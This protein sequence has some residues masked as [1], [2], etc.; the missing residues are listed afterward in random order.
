MKFREFLRELHRRNVWKVA[1]AYVATAAV[2]LEVLTHLFHNFE[3]P[4]WVLKV[5]TTL[6]ITGLPLACLAAW[7]FE[8]KEGGVHSV[9][10]APKGTTPALPAPDTAAPPSI[11]VLPFAD[12]SAERDQQF[13]GDGIAEELLNALASIEG[14]NVAARTSSFSFAGK[15]A[16]IAEIGS[17]LHVRHVLEGS[18]RMS[19]QKLRVT[20]QL[21]TGFHCYSQ[22]YDR[23][24]QDIFE[25]QN[26][27]ARQIV[28]ALLPKLGVHKDAAL[29]TH[30]TSN[31]EAY[32]VRLRAR[33]WITQPSPATYREVIDQLRRATLLDP[34][35]AGAWSDLA[36]I[37]GFTSFWMA[38]PLPNLLEA[39]HA[40]ETALRITP[41]DML[42]LLVRAVLRT[43][44][45][46][47][48]RAADHCYEL[49]R[50]AGGDLSVWAFNRAVLYDHALGHWDQARPALEEA[51]RRDPLAHNVK[52]PLAFN[53]ERSGRHADAVRLAEEL[54][55]LD[56]ASPD[57]IASVAMILKDPIVTARARDSL[58]A[59]VAAA[60]DELAN[61]GH[62]YQFSI[63]EAIG[64][65]TH[66][67]QLLEKLLAEDSAERPVSPVVIAEG[68]KALGEYERA[69]DWW[70]R[71]VD[72]HVP[73]TLGWMAPMSRMHPVIGKNPRFL[74]LLRRMGLG[75]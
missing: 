47:D 33:Q 41:D 70:S 8:F 73:Y 21:V 13:L 53:Y 30:G 31:L 68:Y 23:Q 3:A 44:V 58:A 14:L 61:A 54:R 22:T 18:V 12:M 28:A 42:A 64:D 37:L 38:D 17:T 26:E 65:R 29:I 52:W 69:I 6:L 66:A 24:V 15:G 40:A 1:V 55:D 7:G 75:E 19:G 49:A 34:G 62:L 5:I 57:G 16:S 56:V 74:A 25:I 36:Y 20:A 10:P 71:A 45:Y 43:L 11:A 4:H 39:H 72:Q 63:D 2:L 9:P 46:R 67:R 51:S 27:I 35:Y 48:A 59:M 60:P 50:A 32:N